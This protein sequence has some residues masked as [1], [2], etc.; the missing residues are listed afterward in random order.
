VNAAVA[1]IWRHPIKAHGREALHG[2]RLTEGTTMPWDRTWAV[3]HEAARLDGAGWASPANFS[4]GAKAPALMALTARL[5]E[6][7]EEVTLTHPALG[8][9][10]FA[11]DREAER[12][13]AWI[14][15]IMPPDRAA[16][17]RI[18]R[19]D[20]HG[21]TDTPFPS[22]S[23]LNHASRRVLSQRAGRELAMH[24]FRGNLWIEGLAPW[25]EFDWIG[26]NLRV[27]SAVLRVEERTG[28][29]LAT[30]V[31]PE[32]GR[33]DTDTL[34]IL[35]AGWDHTCFGVYAKVVQTGDVRAG[36]SVEVLS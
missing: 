23:I 9:I 28:R 12:F 14:A 8:D 24:R 3:A 35:E 26:R 7:A 18:V 19:V 16:S 6:A 34:G 20:G 32:T 21:M 22:I 17:T 11:P 15:P 31:D 36:D 13:L 29:C 1:H 2:V 33:R 10:T 4:R 30:T 5:D 27:G 25:E